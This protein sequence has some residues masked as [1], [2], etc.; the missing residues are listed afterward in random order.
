MKEAVMRPIAHEHQLHYLR[1]M[2]TR[3]GIEPAGGVVARL[4]PPLPPRFIAA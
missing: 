2:M 3:L 1:E 4:N